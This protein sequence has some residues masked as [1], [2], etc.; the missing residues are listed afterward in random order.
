MLPYMGNIWQGEILQVKPI[1][2]ENLANK[3]VSAYAKYI[4]GVPVNISEE[5]FDE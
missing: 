5:N 1:G 2:K 3:L 4:F